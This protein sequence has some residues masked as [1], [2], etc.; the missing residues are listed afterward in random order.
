MCKCF[1]EMDCY[2]F[3]TLG[4]WTLQDLIVTVNLI[5]IPFLFI[6]GTDS[7]VCHTEF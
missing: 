1:I 5:K 4:I 3:N 6:A 2:S 7:T